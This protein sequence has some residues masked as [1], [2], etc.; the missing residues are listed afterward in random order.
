MTMVAYGFIKY[1][2]QLAF[3]RSMRNAVL[4]FTAAAFLATA[5]AGAFGALL[6]KYAPVRGG[7]AIVLLRGN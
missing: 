6:N 3:H 5:V 4:G 1:G 2:P 7:D